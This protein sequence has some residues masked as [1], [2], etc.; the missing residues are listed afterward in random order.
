MIWVNPMLEGHHYQNGYVCDNLEAAIAVFKTRGLDQDP[1]IIPVEQEVETPFGKKKQKL[2][3]TM[4][5]LNGLQYELIEPELDEADVYA[6]APH[7]GGEMRFHHVCMRVDDWD[8]FRARV[9]EQDLPVVMER[10]LGADKLRF[11]YLDG[12]KAFGHYLEFIHM[13]DAMWEM[14]KA[15]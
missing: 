6:H 8:D 5:W 7:N 4:F 11:L 13:S 3:I 10:D 2:R 15:M 12:R 9:D 1:M 14:T